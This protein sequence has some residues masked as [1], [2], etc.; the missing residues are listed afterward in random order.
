MFIYLLPYHASI[1]TPT[2][3][4]DG[5]MYSLLIRALKTQGLE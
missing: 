2:V 4:G 3:N 5:N 1:Q